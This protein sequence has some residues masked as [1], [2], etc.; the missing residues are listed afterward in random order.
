MLRVGIDM[1]DSSRVEQARDR[2][3]DRFY[4]R[5][6]TEGERA[7]CG[8]Q[9]LRLA[10]RIAAKE[11]AAKALGCGIGD[12]RWVDV[13]VTHDEHKRPLLLLHGAALELAH[14]LGLTEWE[15]SLTHEGTQAAAVV[16]MMG[17]NPP[18]SEDVGA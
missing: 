4:A 7:T 12:I 1:L 8:D 3:G 13:E 6:F 9:P 15:V 11:A 16:V 10:A 17:L 5:F 18:I 14:S 2:H